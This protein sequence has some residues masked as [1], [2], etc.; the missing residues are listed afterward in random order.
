MIAAGSGVDVLPKLST[1]QIE[2]KPQVVHPSF[3]FNYD[4]MHCG[5]AQTQLQDKRFRSSTNQP[6][7]LQSR[8]TQV[9]T[10]DLQLS[11]KRFQTVKC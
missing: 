3:N 5:R 4:Q 1:P 7:I 10:P 11:E 6:I 9:M 8:E 2:F